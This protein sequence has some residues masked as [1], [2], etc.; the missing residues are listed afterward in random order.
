M[1]RLWEFLQTQ[2]LVWWIYGGGIALLLLIG[3]LKRVLVKKKRLRIVTAR[4][5]GARWPM[6][7]R[8]G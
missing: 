2:G 3:V 4:D 1:T 5:T 7:K 6:R 8:R